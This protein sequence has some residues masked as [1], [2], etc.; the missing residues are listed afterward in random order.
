MKLSTKLIFLGVLVAVILSIS[1]IGAAI[2]SITLVSPEEDAWVNNVGPQ[3]TFRAISNVDPTFSCSLFVDGINHATN[4]SVMNNTDTIIILMFPLS[5]GSHD[6]Y[7]TCVDSD[8]PI[9]ISETRTINIDTEDPIVT[10]LEPDNGDI[11]KTREIDFQFKVTDNFDNQLFCE[12]YID[13]DL[14]DDGNVNNGSTATWTISGLSRDTHDWY[15]TCEDEAGNTGTSST[16]NFEIEEIGYCK[17]GE[18][19]TYLDITLEEP[20]DGD[21]FNI[22]DEIEVKVEIENDGNEDLDIVV[23]AELYDL[24]DEDTIVDEEYETE[25]E[26]D[27][28]ITVTLKL[29]IPSS[30]DED[31]D[32]VVNI[33]VYEDGEEDEQCKEDSIEVDIERKKHDITIRDISLSTDTAACGDSFNLYLSIENNGAEDED[34]KITV[35]NSVL[36]IDFERTLSLDEGEDYTTNILFDVPLDIQEG[37]YLI[38]IRVYYDYYDNSYHESASEDLQLK[39]E[40]NCLPPSMSDVSLILSQTGDVFANYGFRTKVTIT[41]TGNLRTTYNIDVSGYENWATVSSLSPDTLTLDA[42]DVGYVYVTLKPSEEAYGMYDFKVKVSFDGKTEEQS[43]SV[44]VKRRSEAAATWD[45]LWFEIN[46]YWHWALI[47]LALIAAIII[48]IIC[49]VKSKRSKTKPKAT[50]IRLRSFQPEWKPKKAGRK[51]R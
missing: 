8:L 41:N 26:E 11:F 39:V 9:F 3:F 7:I 40:G 29:K 23:E 18:Q 12:L 36:D 22:G 25:I 43:M 47:N 4:G 21:D 10:L 17:Y 16:W 32:F 51:R 20:D 15:V 49:L 6:W 42:G 48:L 19:G 31:N 35:Y 28:S 13:G 38:D 14:E 33:K 46:R 24:D 50:E 37:N 1:L 30:V 44:N 2:T 34:V 5:Q 45:Q 27:E